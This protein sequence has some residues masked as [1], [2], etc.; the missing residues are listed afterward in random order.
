M[1]RAARLTATLPRA[2]DTARDDR[3]STPQVVAYDRATGMLQP[4][5]TLSTRK[6]KGDDS[7]AE[8]KDAGPHV[9]LQVGPVTSM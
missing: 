7:S 2:L 6:R 1:P 3:R 8:G 9:I 4:F 5:Q